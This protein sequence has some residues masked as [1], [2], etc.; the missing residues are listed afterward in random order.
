ALEK[1]ADLVVGGDF[2]RVDVEGRLPDSL[3]RLFRRQLDAPVQETRA[4]FC[5]LY[6]LGDGKD[7][8]LFREMASGGESPTASHHDT[9]SE[10]DTFV[11]CSI[12]HKQV[13]S[14]DSLGDRLDQTR[15]GVARAQRARHVER[16]KRQLLIHLWLPYALSCGVCRSRR[17]ADLAGASVF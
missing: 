5:R 17:A 4:G 14:F 10:T 3:V 2:E 7:D 9:D 8:A 6:R 12:D 15:I 11:V 1:Q 16:I 13:A